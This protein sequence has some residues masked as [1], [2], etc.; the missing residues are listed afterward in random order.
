VAS[1]AN[2]PALASVW[3]QYLPLG[4]SPSSSR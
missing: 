1:L 4:T 2:A 3:S